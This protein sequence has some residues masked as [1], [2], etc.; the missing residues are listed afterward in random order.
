MGRGQRV[1]E[2]TL[3]GRGRVAIFREKNYSAKTNRRKFW[4][5]P[6]EFHLFR[7]TGNARNYVPSHSAE[8][9]TEG[10]QA[11]SRQASVQAVRK[12]AGRH[13]WGGWQA[14]GGQVEGRQMIDI[15]VCR[16]AGGWTAWDSEKKVAYR[17][18]TFRQ[19]D[20]PI[21]KAGSSKAS[22]DRQP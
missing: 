18:W 13:G 15:L 6:S 19:E 21:R 4:F 10:I 7:G 5:I 3:G 14:F 12:Q 11:G 1:R 22:G 20:K 17:Q 8:D 2:V 16:E 9:K